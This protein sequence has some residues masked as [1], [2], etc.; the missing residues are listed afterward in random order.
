MA[1]VFILSACGTNSTEENNDD[2]DIHANDTHVLLS[3]IIFEETTLRH[4]L[5]GFNYFA[6]VNGR[7]YFFVDANE[8]ANLAFIYTNEG[9]I[10]EISNLIDFGRSPVQFFLADDR[11]DFSVASGSITYNHI[12][13]NTMGWLVYAWTWVNGRIPM[14]LAA[15]IEAVALSN[16]GKFEASDNPYILERFGDLYLSPGNWNTLAQVHTIDAAYHFVRYLIDIGVFVD[17]VSQIRESDEYANELLNTHF[18]EFSGGRQVNHNFQYMLFTGNYDYNLLVSTDWAT[19]HFLF[20][21]FGQYLDNDTMMRYLAF[22]DGGIEF[23]YNWHSQYFDFEFTPI[24]RAEILYSDAD[25]PESAGGMRT[26][27]GGRTFNANHFLVGFR[28]RRDVDLASIVHEAVHVMDH[29]VFGEFTIGPFSEGLAEALTALYSIADRESGGPYFHYSAF[30]HHYTNPDVLLWLD[31][32]LY[33]MFG[34]Y[35]IIDYFMERF[36]NNYDLIG[37]AHFNAYRSV[38]H[39]DT[40][41]RLD[42]MVWWDVIDYYGWSPSPYIAS[43]VTSFSFVLYLLEIYGEEAYAQ[44][45]FNLYNFKNVYGV[46]LHEMIGRWKEFLS[47]FGEEIRLAVS[48]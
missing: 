38:F 34:K 28:N 40:L 10:R 11:A 26:I 27:I 33:D 13:Q 30:V 15:G 18:Y 37:M 21:N 5:M 7:Q 14:W 23:V 29:Q 41:T 31:N 3:H 22:A 4:S 24:G 46:T 12:D 19:Y 9:L 36:I 16:I 25:T 20:N 42:R 45:H 2:Q 35:G 48:N 39:W 6:Y 43:Y 44:V 32:V 1:V 8:E 47:D 17:T